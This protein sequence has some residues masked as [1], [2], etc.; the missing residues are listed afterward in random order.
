MLF[1][2]SMLGEYPCFPTERLRGE[3][4]EDILE[5]NMSFQI[6]QERGR[7][8]NFVVKIYN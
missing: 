6:L 7:D 2:V 1:A 4:V 3:V 5:M 8:D